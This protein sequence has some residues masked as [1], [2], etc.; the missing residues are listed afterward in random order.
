MKLSAMFG[1]IRIEWQLIALL[2]VCVVGITFTHPYEQFLVAPG[3][4]ARC[5]IQLG[6]CDTPGTRCMNG[7]CA[8]T[9]IKP[10]PATSGPIVGNYIAL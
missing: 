7:Y 5:G 2:I 1:S 4:R 3:P 10:M 9:A 6:G 8:S